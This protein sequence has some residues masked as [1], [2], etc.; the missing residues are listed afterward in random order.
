MNVG[1]LLLKGNIV[2]IVTLSGSKNDHIRIA[3]KFH[4]LELPAV[5]T[6][7]DIKIFVLALAAYYSENSLDLLCINQRATS[8][9]HAGGSATFRNEGIILATSPIPVKQIHSSTL[10]ATE[11]RQSHLKTGKPEPKELAKAYELAF[12]GLE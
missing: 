6:Q 11:R 10:A 1:G 3:E 12:E 9:M 5:P 4:K 8:G 2:R 7:E